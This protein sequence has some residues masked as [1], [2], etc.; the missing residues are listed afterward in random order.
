MDVF[1]ISGDTQKNSFHHKQ[2]KGDF[3]NKIMWNFLSNTEGGEELRINPFCRFTVDHSDETRGVTPFCY[4]L[5]ILYLW[6][7]PKDLNNMIDDFAGIRDKPIVFWFIYMG[8]DEQDWMQ[9]LD[10]RKA[11]VVGQK[12]MLGVTCKSLYASLSYKAEPQV[13]IRK[14]LIDTAQIF[15]YHFDKP[16]N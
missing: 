15:A 2:I 4:T 13:A 5:V 6:H 8:Q 14:L 9:T 16:L 10:G 1:P 3:F 12:R 7:V 11:Y